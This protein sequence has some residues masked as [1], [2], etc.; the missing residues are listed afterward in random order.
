LTI[1][2]FVILW[3]GCERWRY[4][5]GL[6]YGSL[7]FVQITWSDL[8]VTRFFAGLLRLNAD[9]KLS[10]ASG[11][12]KWENLCP[13]KVVI[14]GNSHVKPF[15]MMF[16]TPRFLSVCHPN[17]SQNE[18]LKGRVCSGSSSESGNKLST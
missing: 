12:M 6:D 17:P 1:E 8:A 9:K 13:Q 15:R 2:Q 11:L 16:V 5:E 18:C 7:S 10:F 14:A 3:L 4:F